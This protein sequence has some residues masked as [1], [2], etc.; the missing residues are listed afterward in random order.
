MGDVPTIAEAGV[1]LPPG[2]EMREWYGMLAPAGTP[3]AIVNKL[4]AEM[5]K[6]FKRPDVQTRLTEMGAEFAGS[7][8]Q[9]LGAQL[10]SDVKTWAKVVQEAGVRAD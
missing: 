10:A 8:P 1:P 7:S 2:L 6:I 3:P 4:N 9:E 5:V